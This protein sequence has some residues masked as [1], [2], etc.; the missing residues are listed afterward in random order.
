GRGGRG[1]GRRSAA[2]VGTG[3]RGARRRRARGGDLT[4]AADRRE[5]V[6]DAI[7]QRRQTGRRLG[8]RRLERLLALVAELRQ[9]AELERAAR[10]VEGVELAPRRRQRGG[11]ARDLRRE[12]EQVLDALAR[13][14]EEQRDEVEEVVVHRPSPAAAPP[15]MRIQLRTLTLAPSTPR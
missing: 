4:L 13:L 1:D 2:L 6:A 3:G 11:R 5:Q 9:L 14:P 7:E 15:Q 10:A 8:S 12:A